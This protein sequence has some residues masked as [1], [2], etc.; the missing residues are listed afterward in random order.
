MERLKIACLGEAMIEMIVEQDGSNARLGVAGD[1]VNTAIYLAR[2][3]GKPHEVAFVS[4]IGIDPLSN[5]IESFIA[6][7][8]VS[9]KLLK[10]HPT[11]LPGLYSIS[12]ND[13][14]ERSFSYWRESSAARVMFSTHSEGAFEELNDFDVV[15]MSAI[16]LAILP[17]SVRDSLFVWLRDFRER[18]G[19]FVFDSNYRPA[20]WP[21]KEEAMYENTRAWSHCDIALPSVDDEMALFGD[22]TEQQILDRVRD[23]GV[24]CGVLKRGEMG[25]ISIGDIPAQ[26]PVFVPAKTVIDTTAAGDSFNGGFL[27]TYLTTGDILLSMENGHNLANRVIAYRGAIIPR[28]I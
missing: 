26:P 8:G 10:R 4:M 3:I 18:G 11:R 14:G 7:E 15:F 21:D 12:T 17:R 27:A 25:P 1:S 13:A 20:L 22:M 16:S 28:Q 2:S 9:T 19:K 24:K 6:N 23:C 5:R